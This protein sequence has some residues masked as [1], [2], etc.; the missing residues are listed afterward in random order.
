MNDG[1]V[2]V[3][4][5][6]LW[7]AATML[8]SAA[9]KTTYAGGLADMGHSDSGPFGISAEARQLCDRWNAAVTTRVTEANELA[10]QIHELADDLRQAAAEYQDSE[11]SNRST[12]ENSGN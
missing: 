2:R 12:I 1:S 10:T 6:D 9:T 11:Q 4:P 3:N 8:D 7:R 5:D